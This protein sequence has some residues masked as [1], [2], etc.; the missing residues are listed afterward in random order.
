MFWVVVLMLSITAPSKVRGSEPRV[1]Q[2]ITLQMCKGIGYN[3]TYMPNMF[4]HDTQLEAGQE[5]RNIF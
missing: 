2:E 5:V 1:C 4:N 3:Y